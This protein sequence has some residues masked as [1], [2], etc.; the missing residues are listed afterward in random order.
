MV[1][2]SATELTDC[3][4]LSLHVMT[5][6]DHVHRPSADNDMSDQ[7][8]V[9][10]DMSDQQSADND[11]SD[12]QSSSAVQESSSENVRLADMKAECV[13]SASC[14]CS[15]ALSTSHDCSVAANRSTE[16][17]KRC[18][19]NNFNV[20]SSASSEFTDVEVA[21]HRL[22]KMFALDQAARCF[23]L[24]ID[25]D[26]FSTVNPFLLSLTVQQYQL[27]SELYAYTPPLNRSTEVWR[28]VVFLY[29]T[30]IGDWSSCVCGWYEFTANFH[31]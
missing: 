25:L 8:S 1:Y 9:D 24:D 21:V 12:Q 3:K 13:L 29:E 23:I 31:K 19:M 16:S 27:L 7:Q 22:S 30:C 10:N 11:M 20:D 14:D 28:S 17:D 26:F 6:G 18:L 15:V 5:L 4:P 2:A